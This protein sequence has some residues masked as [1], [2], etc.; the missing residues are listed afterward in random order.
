MVAATPES[1]VRY[2][3]SRMSSI[4]KELA[5]DHIRLE[6]ARA[7]FLSRRY[8]SQLASLT[9][10]IIEGR[11]PRLLRSRAAEPQVIVYRPEDAGY[12]E[13]LATLRR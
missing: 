9:L 13:V 12:A 10:D 4:Q 8:N 7:N 1:G 2:T 5:A 11:S 6:I 3:L